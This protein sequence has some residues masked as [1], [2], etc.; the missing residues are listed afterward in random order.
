MS[1]IDQDNLQAILD[2]NS[3]ELS[4]NQIKNILKSMHSSE[5]AHALESSPP[6]QRKLIFSLLETSIEGDVLT[7]LGEEI[8]QD[9]VSKMEAINIPLDKF[10]WKATINKNT[11]KIKGIT[12]VLCVLKPIIKPFGDL[13]HVEPKIDNARLYSTN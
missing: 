10:R 4:L 6:E 13:E 1:L 2:A 3:K 12:T 9:L 8:Q 11:L 5:I 7:E